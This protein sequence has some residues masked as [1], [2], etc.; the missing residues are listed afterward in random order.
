MADKE[1]VVYTHENKEKAYC[2]RS[3]SNDGKD[4]QCEKAYTVR[5]KG[6]LHH[7]LESQELVTGA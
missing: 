7:K 5:S 1:I 3:G 6:I 2:I 4:T